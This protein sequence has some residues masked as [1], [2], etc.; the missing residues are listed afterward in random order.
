MLRRTHDHHRGFRPLESAQG[1]PASTKPNREDSFVTR[2]GLDHTCAT[3]IALRP[4]AHLVRD[5]VTCGPVICFDHLSKQPT[6]AGGA[7]LWMKMVAMRAGL[8]E[9]RDGRSC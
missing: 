4:V 6:C 7:P 9:P 3:A 2:H 1:A 5:V 8:S